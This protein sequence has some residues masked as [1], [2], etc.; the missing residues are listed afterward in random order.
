MNTSFLTA[1]TI[2]EAIEA[3]STVQATEAQH[4][5]L[6]EGHRNPTCSK[7]FRLTRSVHGGSWHP[8]G[9]GLAD[10]YKIEPP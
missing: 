1:E 5:C 9:A 3:P 4:E 6:T 7:P 8:V 2:S 10:H